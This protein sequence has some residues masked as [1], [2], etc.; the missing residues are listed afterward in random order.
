MD[1]ATC[2]W[3][4]LESSIKL[5]TCNLLFIIIN[6]LWI[7][8]I[9]ATYC[10]F[11][12]ERRG[13]HWA[14]LSPTDRPTCRVGGGRCGYAWWCQQRDPMYPGYVPHKTLSCPK[15]HL[16]HFCWQNKRWRRSRKTFK[17]WNCKHF[18]SSPEFIAVQFWSH[19]CWLAASSHRVIVV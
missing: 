19:C 13:G 4:G 10:T 15:T 14:F 9:W 2:G 16:W 7:W 18:S 5:K 17:R 6:R 8:F 1:D 11:S 12:H 3:I